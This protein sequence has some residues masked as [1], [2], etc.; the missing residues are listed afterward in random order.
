MRKINMSK[1]YSYINKTLKGWLKHPRSFIALILGAFFLTLSLPSP[2][3]P[4]TAAYPPLDR[5]NQTEAIVENGAEMFGL[6][7]EPLYSQTDE[8]SDLVEQGKR[9]YQAG[10]FDQGVRVG[11]DAYDIYIH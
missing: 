8:L 4:A 1:T 9:Y 7:M 11:Q 10:Q 5:G 3:L 6:P 2:K